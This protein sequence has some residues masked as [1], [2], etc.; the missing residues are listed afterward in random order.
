VARQL[1]DLDFDVVRE[2]WNK[3]E[4]EGGPLLRAKYVLMGVK[5]RIEPD[6]R[7]SYGIKGQNVISV[8]HVPDELKGPPSKK[9]YS[10]EELE[11]SIVKEDIRYSTLR[12]EWNEYVA[13]D[14]ARIRIKF[15]V[16]KVSMT[17]KTDSEGD[18]IYL[19]RSSS[20]PQIQPPKR[21]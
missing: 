15:T 9:R 4:L 3:Y 7:I 18:P 11:A 21:T 13:E 8:S 19:I 20:L 10:P 2:P 12:E 5:K 1:I 16:V 6:G 14:G 17:N